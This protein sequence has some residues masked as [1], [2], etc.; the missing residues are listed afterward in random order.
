MEVIVFA[1]FM[2]VWKGLD[3]AVQLYQLHLQAKIELSR[4]EAKE[5][6]EEEPEREPIGF[7]QYGPSRIE[8][9]EEEE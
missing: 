1:V 6:E 9:E 8:V 2:A 4:P 3:A 5:E 7:V